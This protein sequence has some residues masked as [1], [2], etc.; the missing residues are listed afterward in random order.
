VKTTSTSTTYFVRKINNLIRSQPELVGSATQKSCNGLGSE[1]VAE[2]QMMARKLAI[3]NK[4]WLAIS[5]AWGNSKI[6]MNCSTDEVHVYMQELLYV[7]MDEQSKNWPSKEFVPSNACICC[8]KSVAWLIWR[9]QYVTLTVR[10][11]SSLL[12]RPVNYL[13]KVKM[14]KETGE[15][16]WRVFDFV[17]LLFVCMHTRCHGVIFRSANKPV[18]QPSPSL[19]STFP[20]QCHSCL[21]SN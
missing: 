2:A 20:R 13:C 11:T 21:P 19:D 5:I 12:A 10:V 1:A 3:T 6:L 16:V 9:C 14:L 4:M 8:K 7:V 18:W 17:F 15:R